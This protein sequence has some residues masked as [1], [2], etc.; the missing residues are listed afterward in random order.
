MF[1]YQHILA[2]P[3]LTRIFE[4][5][6]PDSVSFA[7]VISSGDLSLKR[8]MRWPSATTRDIHLLV[9]SIGVLF[10]RSHCLNPLTTAFALSSVVTIALPFLER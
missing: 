5:S 10:L 8:L 3:S 4:D 2:R 6:D 1:V 9:L 7:D